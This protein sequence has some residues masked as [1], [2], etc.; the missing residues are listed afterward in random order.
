MNTAY[1][2]GNKNL[3]KR[4]N[5]ALGRHPKV[6]G[7]RLENLLKKRNGKITVASK[8]RRTYTDGTEFASRMEM[9]RWDYLLKLQLAG[10][11]KNLRKQVPF[12]LQEKFTHPY[13]GIINSLTYVADF[14]YENIAFRKGLNGAEIVEDSKGFRTPEYK[15]KRKLFLKKY[16]DL[17][18]F[19]V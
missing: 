8:E 14:V 16:P 10:E 15:I 1:R 11:I 2:T 3:D 13:Y 7:V 4:I 19:E 12:V 9:E 17:H 6:E 18:F 5:Q